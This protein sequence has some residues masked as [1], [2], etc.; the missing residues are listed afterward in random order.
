MLANLPLRP[1]A[2]GSAAPV[3]ARR[4]PLAVAVHGREP[5][6]RVRVRR[7]LDA[8]R[9]RHGG[10]LHRRRDDPRHARRVLRAADELV[11]GVRRRARLAR[12]RRVVRPRAGDA[13]VHVGPV[14]AQAARVGGGIRL[15]D[16]RRHASG[17]VQRPDGNGHR[18]A[19]FRRHAEP[20]GGGRHR[21]HGVSL[22]VRPPG[23]RDRA[24]GARDGARAGVSDGEHDP[25]PQRQGDRRRLA[26]LVLR[27]VPGAVALA[28]I[29][30]HP[31]LALVVLAYTYLVSAF[32]GLAYSR[33]RTRKPAEP[34]AAE[35]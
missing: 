17:A 3:P 12:R 8:R 24:A 26:P 2:R 32:I 23:S 11:D 25:L 16:R 31:R 33:L 28:L 14:A 22:P 18:Q 30:A 4:V 35:P 27:A 34:P 6:L 20:A 29:A 10:A 7:L 9:L 1:A 15:R 5:V 19:V 13:R 21:G